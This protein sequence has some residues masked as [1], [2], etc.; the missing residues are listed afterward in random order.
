MI[1]PPGR[2]QARA[3]VSFDR[4]PG[5]RRGELHLRLSRPARS[6]TAALLQVGGTSFQLITR[7][8]DAWSSGPSQEAAIIGAMRASGD[9]RLRFRSADG[10]HTDRYLLPG[11]P[12]AID[13]AA[14]ACSAAR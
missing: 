7:G 11:A 1:A 9:M 13:A 3:T 10:A 5:P 12:T 2:D 8:V 14:A 6:G 4:R